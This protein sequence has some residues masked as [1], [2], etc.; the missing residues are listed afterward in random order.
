MEMLINEVYVNSAMLTEAQA[1]R[2]AI[3]LSKTLSLTM[4]S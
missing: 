4:S 2:K 1:V 3:C